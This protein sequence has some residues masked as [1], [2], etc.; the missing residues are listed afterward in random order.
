MDRILEMNA[1]E[2]GGISIFSESAR[3]FQTWNGDGRREKVV[4]TKFLVELH[5][6]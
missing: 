5:I 4:Y 1:P 2:G 6:F 3:Y